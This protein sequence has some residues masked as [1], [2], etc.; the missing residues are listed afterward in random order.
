MRISP[1]LEQRLK[2]GLSAPLEQVDWLLEGVALLAVVITVAYTLSVWS[3]LPAEVP[4][5]FDGAGRPD[6]FGPRGEVWELVWVQ[7]GMYVFFM[8][9]RPIL[10]LV[11]AKYWNSSLT[12]TGGN[13]DRLARLLVRF[14]L[15][16]KASVC[17]VFGFL[18]VSSVRVALGEA[19]GLSPWFTFVTMGAMLG[20]LLWFVVAAS[21]LEGA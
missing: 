8:F 16:M 19:A 1:E 12:V 3:S 18:T 6:R 5:H 13:V 7:L 21:R 20:T 4:T 2:A 15:A 11:P 9:I 10:R 14:L 17:L